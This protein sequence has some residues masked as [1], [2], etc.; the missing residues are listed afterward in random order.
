[1]EN[2]KNNVSDE[3]EATLFLSSRAYSKIVPINQAPPLTQEEFNRP[4]IPLPW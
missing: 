4:F 1:M 3:S 2:T